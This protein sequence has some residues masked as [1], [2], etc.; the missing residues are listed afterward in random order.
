MT[1]VEK[2]IYSSTYYQEGQIRNVISAGSYNNK[3]GM[4]VYTTGVK[5]NEITLIGVKDD[6]SSSEGDNMEALDEE[7]ALSEQSPF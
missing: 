3:S 2:E 4:K 5:V 7:K 6:E 1:K